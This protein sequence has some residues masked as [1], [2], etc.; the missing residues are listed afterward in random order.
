MSALAYTPLWVY[1]VLAFILQ[2]GIAA[3]KANT[4]TPARLFLLPLV[5]SVSGAVLLARSGSLLP[6]AAAGATAGLAAG[7]AAG[8]RLFAGA[9]GYQWDGRR[10]FRPGTWLMLVVSLAAFV[11]KFG[12]AT[13]G[14]WHPELV[15]GVHGALLSGAVAG[16]ASGL[17]WGATVTQLLQGRGDIV[18]ALEA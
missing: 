9:E 12:L 2:R 13:A 10:L 15:A 5:F 3:S 7:A 17:L 4:V 14:G 11:M 1:F 18:P 6:V 8:W 16:I